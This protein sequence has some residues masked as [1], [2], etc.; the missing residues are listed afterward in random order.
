MNSTQPNLTELSLRLEGQIQQEIAERASGDDYGAENT[1]YA[2][3]ETLA[4]MV[5]ADIKSLDDV[6]LKARAIKSIYTDEESMGQTTDMLLM[7]Q[8]VKALFSMRPANL[9][10]MLVLQK[11]LS[12]TP[13]SSEWPTRAKKRLTVNLTKFI[14]NMLRRFSRYRVKTYAK[15]YIQQRYLRRA[16]VLRMVLA[17]SDLENPK[18]FDSIEFVMRG[19]LVV[20]LVVWC[21]SPVVAKNPKPISLDYQRGCSQYDQDQNNMIATAQNVTQK[22]AKDWLVNNRF[23]I[24]REN[25]A[26]L[27]AIA[28]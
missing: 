16:V 19:L 25:E 5:A 20:A 13:F 7:A 12:R 6:R 11:V 14:R 24:S 1:G 10:M 15:T 17:T 22:M 27:K 18:Y 9:L 3:Q 8:V 21:V 4:Q 23:C 28:Q 2:I 26:K